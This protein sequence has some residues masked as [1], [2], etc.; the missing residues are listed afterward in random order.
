MAGGAA[1]IPEANP[2]RT[3]HLVPLLIV[4]SLPAFASGESAQGAERP[5]LSPIFGDNM[6]LQRGKPNTF[7]GWAHQGEHVRVDI[8]GHTA[9]GIAG[10][11]GRWQVQ[12]DPPALE[13][14]CVVKVDGPSHVE[15]HN[16]LVGD[17]WLCGGQS[18]M[19]FALARA[20][21]GAAEVAAADHPKIRFFIVAPRPAYSPA[22]V[23]TGDW[24]VCSPQSVTEE[25]GFSAVAYFFARRVQAETGVP[26]G[27]VE[28]CLGGTPAETW[29][30]PATLRGMRDF[31]APMAEVDRLRGQH[32]P[33]Y[34]NYIM[35]WYD[36]YDGGIRG[37]T[38]ADPG[39]DDASWRTVPITNGF[40]PLG[41]ADV[42]AV[43]WFRRVVTLPDP[44][45]AGE[46]S[47]HLGVVEKME[48]TYF[49][50]EWVGASSWVENPRIY[51]VPAK[52]LKPG[53][54]VL[55]V[56]VLKL[57]SK[58]G[59]TS[60]PE[61]L[62]IVFKGGPQIALAGDWK[63]A[64]SVDARA[65]HPLPLGYENYPTM[66]SVL[67]QGM[68]LPVAPLALKGA[69]WYQG[70]ANANRA[71]Q[72][73]TL[74]PAMI[75]DWRRVFGQ[76]DFPFLI[77]SLPAFEERRAQPSESDWAELRE[78]QAL[79][80]RSVPNCG[81]AITIDTGDAANI[82]PTEKRPVGDRLALVALAKW[83]DQP[84]IFSGPVFRS[85]QRAGKSM[86]VLFDHADGGLKVHGD[87]LGEFSVAG[88]DHAWHWAD[89]RV[90]DDT[91]VVWSADVAAPVAVRYAWQAN[92]LATLFN[93][94]GLPAG[95]F[96][97]DDWPGITDQHSPW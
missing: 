59:F 89:A 50:G 76:G 6:V 21:D 80:A 10:A 57:K 90:E 68:I 27:L 79:T 2:M 43:V 32:A 20:R 45:P 97:S 22:S 41:L 34:G 23:P 75:G 94:A 16:V 18:N 82:H 17:V 91:V 88:N 13:E 33:E 9:V 24:K 61:T 64:A 25:G 44:L 38:W 48:T 81:I 5:F 93:G 40:G 69:L 12:V 35:H 14:T 73:R 87:R 46:A 26:I 86:R 85:A 78:A 53:R 42:P 49:N 8:N 28:D 63:A 47:I 71:H 96:R 11:D 83:Y 84:E 58:T 95:P 52:L 54:N 36:E 31:E 55:T 29:M 3:A 1:N 7:W 60:S 66:P 39:L 15:L 74:L 30:D 51:P 19:Q 67:F 72:Y 70:E 62:K 56:R 92:P 65:P 4:C 77:V 37:S